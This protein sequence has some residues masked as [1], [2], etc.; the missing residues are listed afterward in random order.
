MPPRLAAL[1]GRDMLRSGAGRP[2]RSSS[3]F[4]MK[5][6][7]KIWLGVGAFVLAGSGA[8]TTAIPSLAAETSSGV[9][10]LRARSLDTAMLPAAS[11]GVVMA[12]LVAPHAGHEAGE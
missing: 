9:S 7:T 11:R 6:K 1:R 10:G 5:T 2:D 8:T 4:A 12:Q 3:G